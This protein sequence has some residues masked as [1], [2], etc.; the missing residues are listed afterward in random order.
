VNC[1]PVAAQQFNPAFTAFQGLRVTFATNNQ[2]KWEKQF[3][4]SA[5]PTLATT[6]S[7][8]S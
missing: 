2:L 1:F 7:L 6:P 8:G 5:G 4:Y 3:A